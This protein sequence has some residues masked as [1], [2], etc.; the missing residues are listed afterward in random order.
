MKF[1]SAILAT[2]SGKL[3]GIVA[4]HNR[5]GQYLRKLATP[6][7]PGTPEQEF[8]RTTM[9]DLSNRWAN[10]LTQ[11]QRDA[12]DNYALA[13]PLPGVNG[14]S[15]NVGGVGMFNR[16]NIPRLQA[17]L[18][19]VNDAP[20]VN[21]LGS[22]TAITVA[23]ATASNEHVAIAFD[24]TDAWANEA[25]AAMLVYVSRPQNPSINFFKGPYQLA[26]TI[27]GNA[28]TPPTSPGVVTSPFPFAVGQKI[29]VR[30]AVTRSDGRYSLDQRMFRLGA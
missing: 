4:S 19:R 1:T 12:W 10:T 14:G 30:V 21:D 2:L 27:L 25:G 8:I 15:N 26:G 13:V 20:T 5:G 23:S 9:A 7:N 29:F 22:F 24:N 28:M 18:T 11:V 17:G 6:T 16:S 3:G